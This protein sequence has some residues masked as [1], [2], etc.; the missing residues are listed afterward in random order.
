M[1][2]KRALEKGKQSREMFGKG[3]LGDKMKKARL[4]NC[5]AKGPG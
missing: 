3:F 1:L 5:K 4:W 2:I